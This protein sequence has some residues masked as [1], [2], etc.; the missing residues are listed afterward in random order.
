MQG[1]FELRDFRLGFRSESDAE[2]SIP[3]EIFTPTCISICIARIACVRERNWYI[4]V[5]DDKIHFELI[6]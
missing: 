1:S 3:E 6:S 5:L 4:E 2:T